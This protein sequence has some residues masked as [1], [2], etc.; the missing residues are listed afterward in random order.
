[1]AALCYLHTHHK[2]FIKAS[3]NKI[4]T[5]LHMCADVAAEQLSE[6]NHCG[7]L[8]QHIVPVFKNTTYIDKHGAK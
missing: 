7:L 2:N 5:Q 1:M 4:A 6:F 3:T 8:N